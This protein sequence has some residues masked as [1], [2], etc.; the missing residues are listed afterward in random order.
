MRGDLLGVR[1]DAVRRN[2]CTSFPRAVGRL[3]A[4]RPH[5]EICK[6][7]LKSERADRRRFTLTWV[8]KRQGLTPEPKAWRQEPEGSTPRA[9]DCADRRRPGGAIVFSL[10][11]STVNRE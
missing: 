9:S 6:G 1:D 7:G 2:V 5:G 10:L 11:A 3:S 8:G 4:F